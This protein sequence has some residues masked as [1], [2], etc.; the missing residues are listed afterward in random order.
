MAAGI[1]TARK[2]DLYN[3]PGFDYARYWESRGYEHEA[4]VMAVRRLLDGLLGG[5][6]GGNPGRGKLATAADIGGGYGRLS[7]VLADYAERVTLVDP[8]S[9]QLTIAKRVFP[10]GPPFGRRLADAANTGFED[11]AL[12]LAL[13]VRVLH[14]LPDPE[15]ELAELAR[16]VRPGGYA[17]VEV[18]NS[19]HAARRLSALLRGRPVGEEPV[20]VRSAESRERGTAPFVN[21]HPR[22]ITRQL[23]AA[24]LRPQAVLSV[25]NLRHPAAKAILPAPAMLAVERVA[26]RALGPF[27]FGPSVFFLLRKHGAR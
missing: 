7:V 2:T 19:V 23:I 26:Q 10:G 27:H 18:A 17:I 8:S 12:D 14:H 15:P 6:G 9:Q 11:G 21:H 22:A 24:G 16:V 1:S 13:M 25:S 5:P 20:D 4:E 3:D